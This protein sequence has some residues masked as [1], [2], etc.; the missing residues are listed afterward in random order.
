MFGLI[1]FHCTFFT[2]SVVVVRY[3]AMCVCVCLDHFVNIL[4]TFLLP[5]KTLRITIFLSLVENSTRCVIILS[6][7]K[8]ANCSCYTLWASH[9]RHSFEKK[10]TENIWLII[11]HRMS[12]RERDE[13]KGGGMGV[14]EHREKKPLKLKPKV[15]EY[16]L[17]CLL[18][19]RTRS[20]ALLSGARETQ[21]FP[22]FGVFSITITR[23]SS[24]SRGY[25][26]QQIPKLPLIFTPISAPQ[27]TPTLGGSSTSVWMVLG[28]KILA[29]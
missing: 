1:G 15:R 24:C 9:R 8:I 4:L 20:L 16:S 22:F 28:I 3:M 10:K 14:G 23:A 6:L 11:T 21:L 19:L 27:T 17:R 26:W 5:V 12:S 7:V 2:R 18:M 29:P 25:L 13:N